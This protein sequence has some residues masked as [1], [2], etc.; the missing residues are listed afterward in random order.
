VSGHRGRRAESSISS[1]LQADLHKEVRGEVRFDS[2]ARAMYSTDASNYRQVPLG[3][4]V[5][6]DASD[7]E[8]AMAVARRWGA[9]VLPRGGGTSLAGQGCNE[10]LVVD[11]SRFMRGVV[12]LDPARRRATVLPGTVLDDLRR[13]AQRHGLTFGPDPAT[14]DRCT[15]GGMIG[16]NSCG[17]HSI[18]A[19]RTVDNVESLEVL[20]YDGLRFTVGPTSEEE[21]QAIVAGGGRRG[22]MYRQMK[23]LVDHFAPLIRSRF[24]QIPRRVSGY[25]LDELL[26]ERGFNLARALVGTE[27]TCATVLSADLGLVEI[28]E[29]RAIVVLGYPDV[30]AAAD[31]V[32]AVMAGGPIGLEGFDD[33]LVSYE[34]RRGG[35]GPAGLDLLPE[36]GG[37]LLAEVGGSTHEEAVE[38]ARQLAGTATGAGRW[39]SAAV[40]EDPGDQG[41]I[42]NV[43]EAALGVTTFPPGEA[44]RWGGWEDAAVAPERLGDYL[45]GLRRLEEARGYA[46]SVYGHFG[47]GCIHT[48]IDFDLTTAAGI[49]TFRSFVEEAADLVASLGGSLSGEHGDGQARAELLHRMFGPEL[50]QA[51][52]QFKDIWDPDGRMNPGKVVRPARLDEHLRLGPT[53]RP[54]PVPTYFSYPRDGHRFHR[55]ALRCVGVGKCRRRE[56]GAMCPSYLV[57]GKEEDSTRGRAR[58]LFE[59]LQGEVVAD[60]W[61]SKAVL[62]ALDLCLACKS[63]RAECPVGVDMATYKAEFLAHHYRGRLRPPAHYSMG[64]LP[65]LSLLASRA[66]RAVNLVGA[67]PGLGSLVKRAGGIARER[68]LPR[69][70]RPSLRDWASREGLVREQPADRS[71]LLLWP[72]TFNNYFHPEVGQAA[73]RVLRSAGLAVCLPRP[74]LCCGLTWVSTGQLGVARRVLTRTVDALSPWL[75]AGTPVVVLEPSCAAMLRSDGPELLEADEGAQ[76]LAELTMTLA[77]ALDRLAPGWRPPSRS[78]QALVQYHC[79]QRAVLGTGAEESLLRRSGLDVDVVPPTCCGL[80]GNFGFEAGH[81]DISMAVAQRD[82]LPAVERAGVGELVVADGFSCRTQIEQATGRT[83]HHLAEV[84]DPDG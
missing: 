62:D 59:M 47:H 45:R 23:E 84:L 33:R 49:A 30:V 7:V 34:R 15:L 29:H 6:L 67:A 36:G 16:N 17:V 3:V 5:P 39:P 10:A 28:P 24:P 55:A 78:G 26:P 20:T 40:V 35:R 81:Y 12:E 60:G 13:T 83:V 48:R 58:L 31:A 25:N 50:V 75:S 74:V 57:T 82:L 71:G 1:G 21:L 73:I 54:R 44:P 56:G 11:C 9:A 22:E 46:G 42:W 77:E 51:F 37:W 52:A 76:R 8:A 69:Y 53:Y 14:H 65:V 2:G 72:D 27:G 70:A 32:P 80:A 18:I 43:R 38:A 79:H 64:W 4:V 66:P 19:G 41:R 61:R 63:C 68:P